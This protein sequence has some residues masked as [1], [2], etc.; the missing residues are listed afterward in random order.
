MSL[1]SEDRIQIMSRISKVGNLPIDAYVA[2]AHT[3]PVFNVTV[4]YIWAKV[5]Q[6]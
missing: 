4:P 2:H 5:I 6:I 1:L 3:I